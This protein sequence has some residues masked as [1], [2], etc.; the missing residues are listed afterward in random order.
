MCI[1]VRVI[2]GV[3]M[4]LADG[5]MKLAVCLYAHVVNSICTVVVAFVRGGYIFSCVDSGLS[6]MSLPAS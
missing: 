1:P 4:T 3:A 6:T 2:R 5:W